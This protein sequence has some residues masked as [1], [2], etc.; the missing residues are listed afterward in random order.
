MIS[1]RRGPVSSQFLHAFQFGF[2]VIAFVKP[3]LAADPDF[4]SRWAVG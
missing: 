3:K 4:L 1:S 2:D